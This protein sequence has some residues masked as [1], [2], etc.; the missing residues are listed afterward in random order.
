MTISAT[1]IQTLT[2]TRKYAHAV[3]SIPRHTHTCSSSTSRDL[4]KYNISSAIAPPLSVRYFTPHLPSNC[5]AATF[6]HQYPRKHSSFTFGAFGAV[7]VTRTSHHKQL[8]CLTLRVSHRAWIEP[9][10]WLNTKPSSIPRGAT[11]THA[12]RWGSAWRAPPD[13]QTTEATGFSPTP[14]RLQA[15]DR[16]TRNKIFWGRR[17]GARLAPNKFGRSGACENRVISSQIRCFR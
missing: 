1:C 10:E 14:D 16:Y 13:L 9:G 8:S 6:G 4:H 2:Y 5:R 3:T 17:M 15:G 12:G 7:S 11:P